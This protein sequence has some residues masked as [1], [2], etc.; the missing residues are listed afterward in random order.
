MLELLPFALK[1]IDL[2][3]AGVLT[4]G[5]INELRSRIAVMQAE[6]RDPTDA[7]WNDLFSDIDGNSAALDA[8]DQRLNG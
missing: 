7:E 8:A 1:L 3:E 2:A 6:G 4:V 5:C